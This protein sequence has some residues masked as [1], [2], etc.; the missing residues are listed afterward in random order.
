MRTGLV[1]LLLGVFLIAR[2][3]THDST[4]RNLVDRILGV[5]PRKAAK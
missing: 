4:G 3:V 1:L 2:T 5:K